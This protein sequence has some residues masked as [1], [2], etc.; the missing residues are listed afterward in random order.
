LKGHVIIREQNI[1]TRW[2]LKEGKGQSCVG[3][4]DVKTTSVLCM[5]FCVCDSVLEKVHA[6]LWFKQRV[7]LL[8]MATVMT[9]K[10]KKE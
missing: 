6:N 4:L 5:K 9:L 1:K 10:K 8:E 7:G 2:K 3:V